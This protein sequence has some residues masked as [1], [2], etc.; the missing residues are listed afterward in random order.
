MAGPQTDP[1]HS[2]LFDTAIGMCGLAWS[3]NGV[4][5]LQLP[6]SDRST[7]GNRLGQDTTDPGTAAPPQVEAAI[8]ALRRYFSGERVDFAGVVLD[9][10]DRAPFHRAAYAEARKLGWGETATYGD[11]ARRLGEPGAARAVGRAMAENPIAIIIPCHR[12]LGAGTW[13]GGFSAYGGIVTKER[14]LA[15][16]GV[17]PGGTPML[18]GLLD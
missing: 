10:S 9:L 1:R 16:E 7:T 17:H 4:T 5:R 11:I 3:A 6:E 15:L 8:A 14:L 12:V 18:P 2:I 13:I